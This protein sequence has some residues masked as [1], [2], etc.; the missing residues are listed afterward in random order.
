MGSLTWGEIAAI[1]APTIVFLVNTANNFWG[2]WLQRRQAIALEES[3]RLAK[4]Q[5][6]AEREFIPVAPPVES[7]A[8]TGLLRVDLK[9]IGVM[10]IMML[11][12]WA[13]VAYELYEQ[14]QAS[15]P[16]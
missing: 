12:S 14:H 2:N 11:L 1:V 3:N 16:V 8:T 10:A 9:S 6:T 7:V 5:L 15:P 4:P 13:A